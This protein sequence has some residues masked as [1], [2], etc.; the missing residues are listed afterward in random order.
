MKITGATVHFVN[1]QLD[2]GPIIAQH[3]ILTNH[4]RST[5][6]MSQASRDMERI[7][8]ARTLEL[9]LDKRVFTYRNEMIIFD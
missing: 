2:E 4:T 1:E 9:V 7:A 3:I 8:L 5:R 6:E